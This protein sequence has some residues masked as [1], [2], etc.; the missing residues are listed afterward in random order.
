MKVGDE[1][2]AGSSVALIGNTG[3]STG[4]HLHYEVRYNGQPY[5]PKELIRVK[6]YVQKSQ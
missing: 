4:R 6:R 3:R 5:N 1:V 2:Q